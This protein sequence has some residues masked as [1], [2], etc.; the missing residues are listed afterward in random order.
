MMEDLS[1]DPDP[2]PTTIP[3]LL[4]IFESNPCKEDRKEARFT[5]QMITAAL[6]EVLKGNYIVA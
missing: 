3:F 1:P 2:V 4:R 6:A 5:K